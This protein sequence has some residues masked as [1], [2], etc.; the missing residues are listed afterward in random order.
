MPNP[1]YDKGPFLTFLQTSENV[2]APTPGYKDYEL[3]FG[4]IGAVSSATD[5]KLTVTG[6]TAVQGVDYEILNNGIAQVAAG[7]NQGSFIIRVFGAN[8]ST[9]IPKDAI[10]SLSS[11]GIANASYNQTFKLSMTLKCTSNL[12][13]T[14]SFSTVNFYTPANGGTLITS[15]T[16][17]TVTLTQSG[18]GVYGISDASFGAWLIFYG[19]AATGLKLNDMC[20][21]LSFSGKSQYNDT[22]TISNVSVNGNKLTF[23][24]TTSYNEYGTTTLTRT[25]G[26]SWPTTLH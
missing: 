2:T 14:Y 17:G 26:S 23:K 10:F 1:T 16:T 5:V 18:D 12:A 19:E 13:G 4:T 11:A 24:W 15:P 7:S 21:K 9:T 22:F 6:G 3:K 8:L 25:D 20:G